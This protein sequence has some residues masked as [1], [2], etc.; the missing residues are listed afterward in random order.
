MVRDEHDPFLESWTLSP[1]GHVVQLLMLA[2]CKPELESASLMIKTT[3]YR[4]SAFDVGLECYQGYSSETP[5]EIESEL[6][7][8]KCPYG[9]KPRQLDCVIYCKETNSELDGE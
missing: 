8:G 2:C 5:S 6:I 9:E 4:P 3:R 7:I 1:T